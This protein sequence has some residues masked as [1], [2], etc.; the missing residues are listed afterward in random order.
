MLSGGDIVT[1][2]GPGS[3]PHHMTRA[4]YNQSRRIEISGMSAGGIG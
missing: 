2:A 4:P 3:Q 1:I